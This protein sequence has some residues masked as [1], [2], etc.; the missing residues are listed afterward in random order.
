MRARQTKRARPTLKT[1]HNFFKEGTFSVVHDEHF[2]SG[3]AREDEI[4]KTVDEM[5]E[6][7]R[8]Q[9]P[10]RTQNLEHAIFRGH[11]IVEH[12][13]TQYIRC[14]AS[15]YVDA[16]NLRFTFSQKLEIAY[17]MGFGANDPTLLPTVETLN[18]IRNQ[19]A[20]TF[21]LDR[22]LVD[23]MIRINHE[24]YDGFKAKN[25]RDRVRCLKD[26]CIYICGGTAGKIEA[27]YYMAV[28]NEERLRKDLSR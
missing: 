7:V 4:K 23:E 17:L 16:K 28:D 1:A 14:F 13:L 25:D 24:D 12:V 20:H 22:K 9:F 3:K 18:R 27:H 10:A 26:L 8:T 21:N 15:T 6:L 2:L 11:L 5:L 19:I